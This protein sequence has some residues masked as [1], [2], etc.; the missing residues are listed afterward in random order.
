MLS[1][2]VASQTGRKA[3][4]MPDETPSFANGSALRA[5]SS[6][7]RAVDDTSGSDDDE[8]FDFDEITTSSDS[9]SMDNFDDAD[10]VPEIPK[11]LSLKADQASIQK[12]TPVGARSCLPKPMSS[13][14]EL[15]VFGLL[16]QCIGK[17][18][19][20]ITMPVQLNEPISFLQRIVEYMEYGHLL[21]KA[22]ASPDPVERMQYVAAFAVSSCSS[23]ADRISKPF[24]PLLGETYE[25]DRPGLGYK[26][27]CEQVSHHPPVSAF[28]AT[29]PGYS[30]YGAVCP[31]L[32]F[33]GKSVEIVAKGVNT[34]ELTGHGEIYTWENTKG[35]VHN[36]IIGKLWIE[37][38]G[39][40]KVV[41][42]TTGHHAELN[43]KK[44]T[45]LSRE[46][47]KVEGC[48]MDAKKNKLK[49]IYGSWTDALFAADPGTWENF[50]KQ[51]GHVTNA[52][53]QAAQSAAAGAV[54]P[55]LP[56]TNGNSESNGEEEEEG[57]RLS[58]PSQLP[59]NS[60]SFDLHIPGQVLLWLA[61][62]RPD[63]AA[64][65]YNFTRF[66]I[67]LNELTPD[68]QQL[69]PPT[70]S[71]LRPDIRDLENGLPDAA[72]AR[73]E[74]LEEKQ[75]AT[76]HAMKKDKEEWQPRWY[77]QGQHPVTG[78]ECWL[79]KGNYWNRNWKNCPDIF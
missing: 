54:A 67:Q 77:V 5:A 15:S 79:F 26:I 36:V 37:H 46:A 11:K 7:S 40:M 25:L 56:P 43:F 47:H 62:S 27:V 41:N 71:R 39:L 60:S 48:I 52:L 64:E 32:A 51:K 8:F 1:P 16:K 74:A 20:K 18:L 44:C 21:E 55:R 24:N 66:G 78:S 34:V 69:L 9:K 75:R 57:V 72:A 23:N 53:N 29:A 35:S 58:A 2:D 42:H 17:E 10:L 22:A 30:F 68:M 45:L 73:K 65:Y 4:N 63:N 6:S 61:E 14:G 50:I 19:S 12:R 59:R 76:R 49:Y 33:W 3:A 31:K 28:H 70:D 13:R 38:Y